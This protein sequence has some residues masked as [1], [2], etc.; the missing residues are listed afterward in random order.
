MKQ[1][2]LRIQV[3]NVEDQRPFA[4]SGESI[5]GQQGQNPHLEGDQSAS[6]GW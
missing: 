5:L 2:L 3:P 6:S 1:E 4:L